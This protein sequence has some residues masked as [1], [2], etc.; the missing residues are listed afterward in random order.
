MP[1]PYLTP[2]GGGAATKPSTWDHTRDTPRQYNA[3]HGLGDDS[4]MYEMDETDELLHTRSTAT[5]G[6]NNQQ[7]QMDWHGFATQAG[8]MASSHA[9]HFAT[10][11]VDANDATAVL[12]RGTRGPLPLNLDEEVQA[13]GYDSRSQ[14]MEMSRRMFTGAMCV[15]ADY[16]AATDAPLY[17]Q[18]MADAAYRTCSATA[19]RKGGMR[20]GYATFPIGSTPLPQSYVDTLPCMNVPP[21]YEIVAETIAY[22]DGCCDVE[23]LEEKPCALGD[24]TSVPSGWVGQD[25][26]PND[27][28]TC[29]CKDG[30]MSCTK[31]PCKPYGCAPVDCA[32]PAYGCRWVGAAY[33]PAGCNSNY[34]SFPAY[35]TTDCCMA[36][37]GTLQCDTAAP[38]AA[39]TEKVLPCPQLMCAP[40]QQGCTYVGA[41]YAP[42]GCN[43]AHYAGGATCCHMSCGTQDCT[44]VAPIYTV[45]PAGMCVDPADFQ[46]ANTLPSPSG[47]TGAAYTCAEWAGT[48]APAAYGFTEW[49][50]ADCDARAH[51]HSPFH[52][53]FG[54]LRSNLGHT[55]YGFC[56]SK[57]EDVCGNRAPTPAPTTP[58]VLPA[59][60]PLQ[61]GCNYVNPVYDPVGC[62]DASYAGGGQCCL[63]SC[64]TQDCPNAV[65]Q[66]VANDCAAYGFTDAN[67]AASASCAFNGDCM[68]EEANAYNV[69]D[70]TNCEAQ[71]GQW[72]LAPSP[73]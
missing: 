49:A 46:P 44:T 28:N 40:P 4:Y 35:G 30:A 20:T 29:T 31:L 66:C 47:Y 13:A 12:P 71:A 65:D 41:V 8:A 53:S 24:Y 48:I 27:C 38:T 56:C 9:T 3:I 59:C 37:C 1:F 5:N 68:P 34:H 14:I 51:S 63:S 25:S 70:Q 72:C 33:S 50:Q 45:D 57:N 67:G 60:A 22:N 61:P 10:S 7:C 16:D 32:A 17:E 52:G 43:D 26:A 36:S 19:A 69:V 58:C 42:V 54:D 18:Q 15:A 55:N 2:G 73:Y 11:A 39:P 62:D 64:G 6:N 21:S 23:R